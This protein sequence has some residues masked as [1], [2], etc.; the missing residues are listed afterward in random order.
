MLNFAKG[1]LKSYTISPNETH[2]G[3]LGFGGNNNTVVLQLQDGTSRSIAEN[4][5]RLF[6]RVGGPRRM[7]K[8]IRFVNHKMFS[9]KGGG[10][11]NAAKAL[12]LFTTGRND[13]KEKVDLPKATKALKD[14]G[15]KIFVIGVGKNVDADEV[16][17]IATEP[18]NM[19]SLDNVDNLPSV[20]GLAERFGGKATGN[21]RLCS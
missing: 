21:G 13:V 9:I 7:N 17:L 5:L 4:S 19:A 2:V 3:M 16:K 12:I 11:R 20:L 15:V 10:R 14:S 8:A 1:A 6:K 18:D